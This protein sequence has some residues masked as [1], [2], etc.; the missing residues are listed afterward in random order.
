MLN[1]HL[2]RF[3]KYKIIQI[4]FQWLGIQLAGGNEEVER[5]LQ[6]RLMYLKLLEED[7]DLTSKQTLKK[8]ELQVRSSR[9]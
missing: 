6:D 7:G 2:T 8:I 5:K 9:V 1:Q 4:V 3:R